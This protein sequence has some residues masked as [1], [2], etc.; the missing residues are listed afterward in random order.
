MNSYTSHN[1]RSFFRG[2]INGAD[3]PFSVIQ[4]HALFL[5]EYRADNLVPIERLLQ[6][7]EVIQTINFHVT[8]NVGRDREVR[9]ES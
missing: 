1:I 5:L 6:S 8:I 9:L 4:K 7:Y 3:V 2:Y